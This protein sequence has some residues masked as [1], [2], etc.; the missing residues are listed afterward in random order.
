[1]LFDEG[2]FDRPMSRRMPTAATAIVVSKSLRNIIG[3]ANIKRTVGTSQ[4]VESP[5]GDDDAIF[6]S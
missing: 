2:E 6:S 5:Q 1:M 3:L 4:D